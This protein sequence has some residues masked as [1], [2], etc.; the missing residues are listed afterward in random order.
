LK[1]QALQYRLWNEMRHSEWQSTQLDGWAVVFFADSD[2][3]CQEMNH[4]S[5]GAG[6]EQMTRTHLFPLLT[7][8]VFFRRVVGT[9]EDALEAVMGAGLLQI[10]LQPD[11]AE[12]AGGV[13]GGCLT[14]A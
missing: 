1:E 9:P 2:W 12:L 7:D 10:A 3:V 8:D 6:F 4:R 11:P 5:C 13:S 14:R